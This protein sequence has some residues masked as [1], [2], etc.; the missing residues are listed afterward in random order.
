MSVSIRDFLPPCTIETR[1]LC[2]K[3]ALLPSPDSSASGFHV[4][5]PPL[6]LDM[7][8]ALPAPPLCLAH[9]GHG[10][11]SCWRLPESSHP[12]CRPH[13][14]TWRTCSG[15]RCQAAALG[16]STLST[17][18]LISVQRRALRGS[19]VPLSPLLHVLSS[20]LSASE[21]LCFSRQGLLC[22]CRITRTPVLPEAVAPQ[23][24]LPFRTSSLRAKS[25]AGK[26][27]RDRTSWFGCRGAWPARSPGVCP[28]MC[29]AAEFS[30]CDG[31]RAACRAMFISTV[32]SFPEASWPA[33]HLLLEWL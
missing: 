21:C 1:V 24:L 4:P 23:L 28:G 25:G 14:P 31:A 10:Q 30:S 3:S 20:L 22:P 33:A 9:H 18:C 27:Q 5:T 13:C 12:P 16:P 2:R 11:T 15:V 29:R 8:P 7:C 17:T 6:L 19:L 32:G 26:P